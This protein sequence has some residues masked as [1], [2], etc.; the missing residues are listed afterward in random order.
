MEIVNKNYIKLDRFDILG[1]I[2]QTVGNDIYS[3]NLY[4]L[5]I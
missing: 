5:L 1:R 3:S 4:R 2:V